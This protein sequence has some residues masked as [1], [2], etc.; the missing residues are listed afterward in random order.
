MTPLTSRTPL[1]QIVS[2]VFAI[3]LLLGTVAGLS[4]VA[5]DG[6]ATTREPPPA[7]ATPAPDTTTEQRTATAALSADDK[8]FVE[9]ALKGGIAEVQEVELAQKKAANPQLRKA[10]AQLEKEHQALNKELGRIGTQYGVTLPRAPGADRQQ[11]Y[12]KLEKLADEQFDQQFLKAGTEAHRKTIALFERTQ[13]NSSNPDIKALA[14]DTL[15]TLR[16]HLAM[17]EDLQRGKKATHNSGS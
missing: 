10:A 17:L 13:S 8:S 3:G 15:P 2:M 11:L 1:G 5:G 6:D 16:K 9:T 7:A 14:S 12:A 4:A